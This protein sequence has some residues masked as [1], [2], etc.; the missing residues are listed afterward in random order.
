MIVATVMCYQPNGNEAVMCRGWAHMVRR[1]NPDARLAIFYEK[2][3]PWVLDYIRGLG[4]VEFHRLDVRGMLTHG[5][6]RGYS[7]P[8]VEYKM[9][10]WSAI[11]DA[12]LKRLVFVD[13]DAF[14][15]HPLD[16]LWRISGEKMFSAV[17]EAD[18]LRKKTPEFPEPALMPHL[19]SGVFCYNAGFGREVTVDVLM[20][21]Y[22]IDHQIAWVTG[23]QG[24]LNAHF[25]KTGYD[26][27]HKDMGCE[28]NTMA[29]TS[30]VDR[31][32]DEEIVAWTPAKRPDGHGGMPGWKWWGYK[33]RSKIHHSLWKKWWVLPET[34][35]LWN[36]VKSKVNLP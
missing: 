6:A 16:T 22:A 12:G 26:W 7:I 10:L 1:Y 17:Y 8:G 33:A 25:S 9:A 29:W 23:D 31:A 3:D 5:K 18:Y 15:L 24:L 27:S 32:D 13:A 19:N 36:Y 28:W 4:N 20:E 34:E 35:K 14:V 30:S 21:Q 2:Q 11:A